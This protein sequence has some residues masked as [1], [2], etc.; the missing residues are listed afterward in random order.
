MNALQNIIDIDF[1]AFLERMNIQRKIFISFEYKL[2]TALYLNN[3]KFYIDWDSET[4]ENS[5]DNE[6][7]ANFDEQVQKVSIICIFIDYFTRFFVF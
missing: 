6:L 2:L 1:N 4:Y 3:P 7:P 5:L